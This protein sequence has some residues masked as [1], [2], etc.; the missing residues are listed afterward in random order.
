MVASVAGAARAGGILAELPDRLRSSQVETAIVVLLIVCAIGMVVVLRT[1]QKATTRLL[2]MGLLFV[3]GIGL[4]LQREELQ[5]CEGQ[6]TC[7]VFGMDVDLP[8]PVN[9]NCPD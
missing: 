7:H 9:F 8:D 2:A 4:W 6:C 3:V 1:V 5:D